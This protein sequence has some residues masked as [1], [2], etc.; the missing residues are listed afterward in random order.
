M[1]KRVVAV[2]LFLSF[3]C[4]LLAAETRLGRCDI[5]AYE[6]GVQQIR[7]ADS[8]ETLYNY[9][10]KLIRKD[11]EDGSMISIHGR[12]DNQRK[13]EDRIEW[14]EESE[15]ELTQKGLRTLFWRKRSSG[16]EQETWLLR[17]DWKNRCAAY[18]HEDRF[19]GKREEKALA[20]GPNAYALDSINF[21]LRGFP[22]EKGKGT[23][24][25]GEFILTDGSVMKGA[26]V[27]AGEERIQTGF[28][29]LE[30]YKLEI[31]PSGFIGVFAPRMYLWFTKSR[32][33]LFLRYDGKDDGLLKPRTV[34]ELIG[35]KP[36]G[37]IHP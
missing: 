35:Y 2:T 26:V 11:T 37:R 30:A 23:R 34:N 31:D 20:F 27:H 17:Y 36:V 22:F 33:H 14:T 12:G 18:T 24:L 6:S 7:Y 3:Q 19:S 5:G 32:P 8:D 10:W 16:A 4:S 1:V 21:Q 29:F 9:Q 25:E 15:L 28:G 13:G